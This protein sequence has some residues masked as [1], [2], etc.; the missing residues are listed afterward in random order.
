MPGYN[1]SGT[2]ERTYNW[3][4]DKA[5]GTKIRADRMDTEMDGFATGLSTAIT[6]DGQTTV[7]ADLPMNSHKFTGLSAGSSA[8]HSVRYEQVGLLAVAN[9][10]TATQTITKTSAGAATT[11][12]V[13]INSDVTAD[14]EVVLDLVPS[15]AGAG[16]RGAQVVGHQYGSNDISLI[17][18]AS[19]N[20]G[21]APAARGMVR[22]GL[23]VGST[24][25]ADDPGTGGIYATSKIEL[26]HASDTTITRASAGLIAVE[27]VTLE[28]GANRASFSAHKNGT[29]QTGVATATP[30][31]VTFGT[32]AYDVGAAF[33]SSTWTPPAGTVAITASLKYTVAGGSLTYTIL[34][35]YKNG[36]PYQSVICSTPT[37]TSTS[38][39]ATFTAQANGTDTF[40]IY[41]YHNL[42]SDQTIDGT[43]AYTWVSGTMI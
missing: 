37:A 1:G 5:A 24:A 23:V 43:A 33:A 16:V 21:S 35:L 8:G 38:A 4:N 28:P 2:F 13:L 19:A 20:S 25:T 18:K 14:T 22:L 34:H 29:D 3:A 9:A 26:G 30:T 32:E 31:K 15:T 40:E 17:F 12:L 42:G 7:A 11:G 36:S 41:V 39:H 10:W 6:K 27:G